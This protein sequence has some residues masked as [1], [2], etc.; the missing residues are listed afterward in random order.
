MGNVSALV[1][2][3][4]AVVLLTGVSGCTS[5]GTDASQSP[6]PVSTPEPSSNPMAILNGLS[7]YVVN[8]GVQILDQ[9][10]ITGSR[11]FDVTIPDGVTQIGFAAMCESASQDWTVSAND[12]QLDWTSPGECATKAVYSDIIDVSPGD[13][14]AVQVGLDADTFLA[15]VTYAATS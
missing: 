11:G 8:T 7:V 3:A 9:S 15:I 14:L 2:A 4:I 5:P 6:T 1:K 13:T 10:L 12:D